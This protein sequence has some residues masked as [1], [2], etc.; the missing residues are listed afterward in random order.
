MTRFALSLQDVA[1]PPL[2]L[3]DQIVE[4]AIRLVPGAQHAAV[5]TADQQ[6]RLSAAVV[7]G[8]GVPRRVMALQNEWQEGPCRDAIADG[9]LIVAPDVATDIRWPSFAPAAASEGAGSMLCIPLVVNSR[10][11]GALTLIGHADAFDDEAQSLGRVFAAHAAIALA[12]AR[13]ATNLNTALSSRDVI[14]QAK[15]ILME[16]F[17]ITPELAFTALVKASADANVKLRTVCEEL[18]ET[19]LLVGKQARKQ[20]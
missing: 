10:T 20:S 15:G 2:D 1:S 3:V 14:G 13:T 12:A 16:R 19:G 11:L 5:V 7:A 4:G 18:C 8:N 6:G 17:R 9:K